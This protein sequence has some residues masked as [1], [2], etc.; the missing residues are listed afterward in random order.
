MSTSRRK[1]SPVGD[2]DMSY[3]SG[4]DSGQGTASTVDGERPNSRNRNRIAETYLPSNEAP[5]G[6][7]VGLVG[8]LNSL[9]A[10]TSRADKRG[11]INPEMIL[12]YQQQQYK[13]EIQPASSSAPTSSK[14][15]LSGRSSPSPV[16]DSFSA[17]RQSPL[18]NSPLRASFTDAEARENERITSRTT[19]R[20]GSPTLKSYPA[21]SSRL[22]P[23]AP[24]L[25]GSR[26][27]SPIIRANSDTGPSLDTPPRSSSLTDSVDTV[28]N[29]KSSDRLQE[30]D[31]VTIKEKTVYQRPIPQNPSTNKSLPP[32]P[33]SPYE[34]PRIDAPAWSNL[35]FSLSDP[36]FAKL[37]AD[38]K[39]SPEKAR[40]AYAAREASPGRSRLQTAAGDRVVPLQQPKSAAGSNSLPASPVLAHSP[41]LQTIM[42]A[43]ASDASKSVGNKIAVL[44]QRS[45]SL[46][47]LKDTSESAVRVVDGLQNRRPGLSDQ[48]QSSEDLASDFSE[49]KIP[50]LDTTL[51]S[52]ET[53]LGSADNTTVPAGTVTIQKSLLER[54]VNEIQTLTDQVTVLKD[55]YS[56]ARV[57][58]HVFDRL[59]WHSLNDGF[60]V[61]EN[62]PSLYGGY[63]SCGRR[64]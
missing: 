24:A 28:A 2:I 39:A 20:I 8:G 14:D 48:R 47:S 42:A 19:P 40:Q 7:G 27:R 1:R 23:L 13:E 46:R 59:Y 62:Q 6:L 41:P 61:T 4:G 33:Q 15:Y 31:D 64:V 9:S 18:P 35:G 11:S 5:I 54:V 55:K 52:L 38:N 37:L 10:P 34:A 36:D 56:G 32:D 63:D 16:L 44:P 60:Y 25:A 30:N 45:D 53:L 49:L 26:A 58:V 29:G 43:Y 12:N 3:Y 57:S 51:P 17:G 50:S 21:S 22:T